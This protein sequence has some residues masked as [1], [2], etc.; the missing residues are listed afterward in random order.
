LAI[1]K[2]ITEA[3]H[4]HIEVSSTPGKGTNFTI[5]LPAA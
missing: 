4:G 5:I 1:A 2:K 3:H